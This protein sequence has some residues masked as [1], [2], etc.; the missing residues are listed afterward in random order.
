MNLEKTRIFSQIGFSSS[1]ISL[2]GK[3][4]KERFDKIQFDSNSRKNMKLKV[5]FFKEMV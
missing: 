4:Q 3:N 1:K 2:N 5:F